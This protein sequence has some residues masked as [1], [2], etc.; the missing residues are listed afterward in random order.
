MDPRHAEDLMRTGR[1]LAL[2]ASVLALLAGEA[3]GQVGKPRIVTPD[4]KAVSAAYKM[5]ESVFDQLKAGKN[6]DLAKWLT[7]Q[8]GFAWDASK[9]VQNTSEYKTKLDMIMLSPPSGNYGKL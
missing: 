2:A 6:E 4:A 1:R 8:I 7:D 5:A 9:K 3:F